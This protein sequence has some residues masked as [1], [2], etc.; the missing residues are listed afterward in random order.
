MRK[1]LGKA[2][3]STLLDLGT[4]T[5][6]ILEL[7]SDRYRHG[8]GI[9]SSQEMLSLARDKLTRSGHDRAQVRHG[10]IYHLPYDDGTTDVVV[11]HQVLHYLDDPRGAI[12]EAGRVLVSGGRMLIVDFAPHELD[13]LRAEHAHL[14]LG[15]APGQM[16]GWLEDAGLKPIRHEALSPSGKSTGGLTV[17]LWLAGKPD[18]PGRAGQRRAKAK[19]EAAS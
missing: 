2:A 15:I 14:R 1:A 19:Q 13:F 6:R 18:R 11:F 7:F 5:G 16:A 12:A 9:D 4:G 3:I 10:D 17:L 8:I